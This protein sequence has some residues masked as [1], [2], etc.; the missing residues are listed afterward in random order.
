VAPTKKAKS[1]MEKQYSFH[2]V[3]SGLWGFA[4]GDTEEGSSSW[5][6]AS[7]GMHN[8]DLGVFLYIIKHMKVILTFT[9]NVVYV[10]INVQI[11]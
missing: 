6:F 4:D 3:A 9:Y 2:P 1:E 8:D 11:Y 5:A 10:Y 7:D